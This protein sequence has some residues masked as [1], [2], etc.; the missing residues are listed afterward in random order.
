MKKTFFSLV[1]MCLANLAHAQTPFMRHIETQKQGEGRRNE[2]LRLC[3]FRGVHIV[4][5]G[6]KML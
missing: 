2:R 1:L 4:K 5:K 3:G 6:A